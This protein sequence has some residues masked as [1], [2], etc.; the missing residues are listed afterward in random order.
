MPQELLEVHQKLDKTVEKLYRDKPF[1]DASERLE[2]LLAHYEELIKQ[3]K[4]A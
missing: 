4:N 1:Q 2:F 3:E